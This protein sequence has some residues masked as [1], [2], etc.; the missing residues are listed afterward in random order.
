MNDYAESPLIR[1]NSIG[2]ERYIK[3]CRIIIATTLI[4]IVLIIV[5]IVG[6]IHF[7][8]YSSTKEKKKDLGFNFNIPPNCNG[9]NTAPVLIGNYDGSPFNALNYE[10]LVS[11]GKYDNGHQPWG[12]GFVV[13][14]NYNKQVNKYSVA[15]QKRSDD[16]NLCIP[17]GWV[18]IEGETLRQGALRELKEE[19]MYYTVNKNNEFIVKEKDL[20]LIRLIEINKDKYSQPWALYILFV[21]NENVLTGPEPKSEHEMEQDTELGIL[22]PLY[23]EFFQLD[24]T[25]K[26]HPNI[27]N[28]YNQNSVFV[29]QTL[30]NRFFDHNH[31]PTKWRDNI[32]FAQQW[33]IKNCK[34]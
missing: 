3:L 33:I 30:E 11:T 10:E 8:A 32:Q 4:A 15:L 17:G 23:H 34:Y 2:Y 22:K 5:L 25:N 28:K 16:G 19:A 6:I 21:N 1:R 27:K 24:I 14:V 7:G 29:D 26:T 9:N 18:D 31:R 20:H 13:V 12:F